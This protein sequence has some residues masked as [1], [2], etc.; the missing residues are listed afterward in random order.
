[1][2]SVSALRRDNGSRM[3]HLVAIAL[4]GLLAS[5][6]VAAVGP[7]TSTR[8][9][10]EYDEDKDSCGLSVAY[11]FPVR[12]RS[13]ATSDTYALY[14]AGEPRKGVGWWILLGFPTIIEADSYFNANPVVVTGPWD[15]S[16]SPALTIYPPTNAAGVEKFGSGL[17]IAGSRIAIGASETFTW[18]TLGFDNDICTTDEF[19]TTAAGRVH[20]YQLAGGAATLERTIV[21]G[22]LGEQFGAAADLDAT[23]LLVG[24]PGAVPG[25]ADVF[26]PATGNPIATLSSNGIGDGF[27]TS[28]VLAGDLAIIAAPLAETVYVYRHDGAGNWNAAGTLN[29]PGVGSEFGASID[30]DGQRIIV[31]APAIDSAYIF[32]DDGDAIWPVVASLTGVAASGFGHSVTITGDTAFVA[33]PFALIFA[34]VI[35]LVVRHELGDGSWPFISN[36]LSRAPVDDDR[37][38]IRISASSTLLATIASDRVTSYPPRDYWDELNVLTSHALTWDTDGDG[39]MQANDNCPSIANSDQVD[40]DEDGEGD[41]CDADIDDDDLSNTD[42]AIAGTDPFDPDSDDDGLDDGTEVAA[43]SNPLDDDTD[44]DGLLDAVDPDPLNT[45]TDHDGLNDVDEVILGTDPNDPDTD[46]DGQGDAEDPF[47]LDLHDGWLQINRL[48]IDHSRVALGDKLLLVVE[49]GTQQLLT[50]AK[51]GS[52]WQTVPG[53]TIGAAPLGLVHRMDVKDKRAVIVEKGATQFHF[54]FHVV[55]YDPATGWTLKG[56]GN[57]SSA[58]SALSNIVNIA[59]DGDAIVAHVTSG[60]S[61]HMVFFE[62]TPSGIQY[63]ADQL[64]FPSYN[65]P[66]AFSDGVA[67]ISRSVS[68]DQEGVVLVFDPLNS[69]VPVEVR[70]PEADRNTGDYVGRDLTPSGSQQALVSSAVGSFTVEK[71][72]GTW[73][74][75]PIGVPTTAVD[76]DDNRWRSGHGGNHVIRGSDQWEVFSGADQSLLGTLPEVLDIGDDIIQSN[77]SAVLKATQ[78]ERGTDTINIYYT[79]L[80]PPGC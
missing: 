57:S 68:Y 61:H 5:A 15:G 12:T 66:M 29:S 7:D 18:E 71:V 41:I 9:W 55:D 56:S 17:A 8:S 32:E 42:E 22:A 52:T 67:F 54:I 47:P 11:N 37:F 73:Q 31:G 49:E 14:G 26:D 1:M 65:G 4:A 64:G 36:T 53:P 25:A 19:T 76:G 34:E 80:E 60:F 13:L 44:G 59:V 21:H 24:R 79:Y 45:D 27:G 77:G 51:T 69:Y 46:D 10:F 43:G 35:G 48:Q 78:V 62:V 2:N 30:A 16:P 50:L 33:A 72:A 38:G 39:V 70:R 28:V 20:L 6:N 40:F 58:L 75:T 63:V 3:S 23:H 74:L